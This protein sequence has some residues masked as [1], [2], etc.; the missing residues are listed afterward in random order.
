M[1]V[2]QVVQSIYLSMSVSFRSHCSLYFYFLYS[3]SCNHF[4]ITHVVLLKT[5]KTKTFTLTRCW[6]SCSSIVTVTDFVHSSTCKSNLVKCHKYSFSAAKTFNRTKID[7]SQFVL[8]NKSKCFLLLTM[9]RKRM[10]LFSSTF[11][12]MQHVHKTDFTR[13]CHFQLFSLNCLSLNS[14]VGKCD[15]I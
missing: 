1:Y 13:K 15:S 10:N 5:F 2:S 8:F 3:T 7:Q 4:S 11:P 14:I 12:N 6:I 9:I